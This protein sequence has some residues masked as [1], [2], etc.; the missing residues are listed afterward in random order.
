MPI[1]QGGKTET[2]NQSFSS[3]KDLWLYSAIPTQNNGTNQAVVVGT[4]TVSTKHHGLFSFQ[5]API[6]QD[7][8][9]ANLVLTCSGGS[10]ALGDDFTVALLKSA[11][12]ISGGWP[13]LEATWNRKSVAAQWAGGATTGCSVSGTDFYASPITLFNPISG[14]SGVVYTIDVTALVVKARADNL[15]SVDFVIFRASETNADD[16]INIRSVRNVANTPPR[17]DVTFPVAIV[18]AS[19]F[20]GPM[21]K[22]MAF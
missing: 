21:S 5:I 17:L 16:G 20:I 22:D 4:S 1:Q 7:P 19:Q 15:E 14:S 13:V 2:V 18:G 12:V 8:S 6:T 3:T 11:N 10:N 9:L